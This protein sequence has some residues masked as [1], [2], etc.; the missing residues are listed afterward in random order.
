MMRLVFHIKN[1]F[2]NYL[3]TDITLSKTQLSE[4]IQ[5]RGFL[6]EF[7]GPLLKTGLALM[8]NILQTLTKRVLIPLGLT[9]AASAAD[10]GINKK[11]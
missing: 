11:S 10:V 9:A 4:K 6:G 7:L 8:K 5:S 1:F 2:A 3:S